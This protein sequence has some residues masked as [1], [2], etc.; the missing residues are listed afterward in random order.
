MK[1]T[2]LFYITA[3]LCSQPPD[4]ANGQVNVQGYEIGQTATYTCNHGFKIESDNVFG[5]MTSLETICGFDSY[6]GAIWKPVPK[7]IGK[8]LFM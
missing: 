8:S 6:A 5:L 2:V 1:L 4:V 3:L 7:C